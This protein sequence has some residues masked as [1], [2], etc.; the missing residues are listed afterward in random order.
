MMWIKIL[1]ISCAALSF[2]GFFIRGI[3]MIQQSPRLQQRWVKSFP[4]IID[5]LLLGSAITLAIQWHFSPLEQP[6]L[7]AKIIALLLYIALGTVALKRGK[8]L[9]IRVIAWLLALLCFAYIVSVAI[10]KSPSI[11]F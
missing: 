11:G 5:T 7:A 8:T 4:H 9:K 6:W 1:H 2:C 10:S 3:W